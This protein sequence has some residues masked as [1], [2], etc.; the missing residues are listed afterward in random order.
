MI[1]VS[2]C[3]IVKNEE[4]DI[5]AAKTDSS[6]ESIAAL[7]KKMT[8]GQSGFGK[9]AKSLILPGWMILQPQEIFPLKKPE[10][11]ISTPQMLTR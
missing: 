10:W 4:N 7:E 11:T 8:Q 5:E 1:T 3:L 9:Y 6:L 2:A